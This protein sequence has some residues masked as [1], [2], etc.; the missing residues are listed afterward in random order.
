MSD[1]QP[2]NGLAPASLIFSISPEPSG[3]EGEALIAAIT[4]YLARRSRMQAPSSQK[5]VVS[6]W[7]TAGRK[8]SVRALAKSPEMGW[9][10]GS[11]H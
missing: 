5:P 4:V 7:L 8:Q 11:S 2:P 3:D 10:R 9:G 1:Q 6:R